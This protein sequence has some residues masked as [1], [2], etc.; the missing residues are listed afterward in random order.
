M[1]GKE[2]QRGGQLDK[3]PHVPPMSQW[4]LSCH[5][6]ATCARQATPCHRGVEKSEVL[7]YF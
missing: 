7:W 4:C 6:E 2:T 5:G 3:H 1:G